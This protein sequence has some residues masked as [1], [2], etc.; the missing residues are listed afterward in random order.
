M[1]NS[2]VKCAIHNA[3]TSAPKWISTRRRHGSVRLADFGNRRDP[4][5]VRV[6]NGEHRHV[7]SRVAAAV[8]EGVEIRIEDRKLLSQ[9]EWHVAKSRS[10]ALKHRR[11]VLFLVRVDLFILRQRLSSRQMVRC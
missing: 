8:V 7:D 11:E 9:H 4:C 10:G 1:P 6:D 2:T 3:R 5:R